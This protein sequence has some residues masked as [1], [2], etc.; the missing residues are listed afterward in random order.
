MTMTR[1]AFFLL[2]ALSVMPLAAA[3]K[4][5]PPTAVQS[6][7]EQRVQI[8]ERK[9]RALSG[10]VLDMERLQREM[11]QLRGELELQSHAIEAQK[12]HMRDIY[13]DIDRRFSQAGSATA[14]EEA[15]AV[16]DG[17]E[18]A[19]V[20]TGTPETTSEVTTDTEADTTV[21]TLV[22]QSEQPKPGEEKAYQQAFDLLTQRRYEAARKAFKGFL[23]RYPDGFYADNAQYWLGE[24]SYVTR[25]FTQAE[26]EFAR[27]L[28]QFPES[29][30]VPGAMLKIGYIQYEQKQPSKARE[31]L[32]ALLARYPSST[33][34]RLAQSFI[35]KKG[36]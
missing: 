31:T 30:K 23:Q 28:S 33:A 3:E 35:R 20:A 4:P 10:L 6:G 1:G 11:Q 34:A 32:Q 25:D 9:V 27:V 19:T 21:A 29:H 36:L 22:D 13:L 8:L 5:K 15:A 7:L 17:S 2:A 14:D 24:A 12:Q 18:P 16:T 26:T